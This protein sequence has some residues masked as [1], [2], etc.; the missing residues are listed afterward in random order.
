MATEV[1]A[2][3]A[4]AIGF[5]S[6]PFLE[7]PKS[8]QV[9]SFWDETQDS[10]EP[11]QALAWFELNAGTLDNEEPIA[12]L[13]DTVCLSIHGFPAKP[14]SQKFVFCLGATPEKRDDYL[15]PFAIVSKNRRIDSIWRLRESD[16][17]FDVDRLFAQIS[18]SAPITPDVQ[19]LEIAVPLP[20]P[21]IP[22]ITKTETPANG[23]IVP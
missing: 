3:L 6:R 5:A 16:S 2:S 9:V 18:M 11:L 14:G 21:P 15:I 22:T 10:S 8:I 17:I 20:P 1:L 23:V 4:S 7:T 12:I 19:K 13:S